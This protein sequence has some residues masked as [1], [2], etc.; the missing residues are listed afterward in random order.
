MK[1]YVCDKYDDAVERYFKAYRS[2]F[3]KNKTNIGIDDHYSE[4][5]TVVVEIIVGTSV[6]TGKMMVG[7]FTLVV[8][9]F[10][11]LSGCVW[12]SRRIRGTAE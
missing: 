6:F 12:K 5:I 7:D 1:S 11:N 10:N 2:Q 4:L 3:V 9:A 8:A